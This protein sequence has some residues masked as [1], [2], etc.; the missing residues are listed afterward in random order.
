[1]SEIRTILHNK[2]KKIKTSFSKD[3]LIFLFCILLS[4]VFWFL[5]TLSKTKEAE[6]IIPI[7]YRNFPTNYIITDTLHQNVKVK[8]KDT[9][10]S[11]LMYQLTKD[12]KDIVINIENYFSKNS[13]EININKKEFRKRVRKSI[14]SSMIVSSIDPKSLNMKYEKLYGKRLPVKLKGKIDVSQQYILKDS[15]QLIPSE[16]KVYGSRTMLN[17]LS[18]IY[19][20]TVTLNNLSESTKITTSPEPIRNIR[21]ETS[22]IQVVIPVE[23]YTEKTMTIPIVGKNF[24][25]NIQ[26][27]TFPATVDVSFI[28]GLSRFNLI[29]V[30]D[31]QAYVDY[32]LLLNNK[33]GKQVVK[34]TT[35]ISN[36]KNLNY[37]PKSVEYILEEK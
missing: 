14:S 25:P 10:F 35:S 34:V 30:D 15:I 22:K 33:E 27:K 11:I 13:N 24:P 29:K 19:T 12:K 2:N 37:S 20:K 7:E 36:I 1:M 26:L 28:V 6:L 32:E 5:F 17:K 18:A 23:L 16:I 4:T 3:V 21:F 31:I 8:V 9:G